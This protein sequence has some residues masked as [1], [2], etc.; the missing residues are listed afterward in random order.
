MKIEKIFEQLKQEKIAVIT[1]IKNKED[2]GKWA[3]K[4]TAL[5]D[6]ATFFDSLN[7]EY[8]NEKRILDFIAASNDFSFINIYQKYME[9]PSDTKLIL[10]YIMDA[11]IQGS[12]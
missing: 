11:I 4:I 9:Y 7:A 10:L 12:S 5:D 3:W 1:S 6:I 2:Y 8:D